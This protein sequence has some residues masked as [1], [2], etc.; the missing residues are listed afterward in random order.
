[1]ADAPT[2]IFLLA[3]GTPDTLDDV[4]PYFTH[5]RGGRTP[6][7]EAI[8]HLKE[9]YAMLGGRT[10]LT[11]ITNETARALEA[12]LNGEGGDY[13]A[14]VGMKHWHP[15]IVDVMPRI[16]ADGVRKLIAIVLAPH[17][18]SFSVAGYRKYVEQG[19]EKLG[20]PFDITFVQQ[21]HLHPK[22]VEMIAG[23]VREQLDAFAPGEEPT[24]LFSAHSLPARIRD[25]GDPYEQQLLASCEAVARAMGLATWR[26]A[27]QSA[28]GT[29]EPWLGPDI[30]EYLETMRAEGITRVVSCPIG[31]VSDHLEVQFDIDHEAQ[32]KARELGMELRRTRMPNATPELI[33]VLAAI[34]RDVERGTMTDAVRLPDAAAAR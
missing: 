26:F 9:R 7:P 10:P 19:Q 24:V 11:D 16:A 20:H 14:Y 32:Q 28:G 2:G 13:R 34:V 23:R 15:Y 12:R 25:A 31:F 33:A 3:Y 1:M 30:L 18:S 6:S 27:W 21:W 17:Y 29:S 22:F 5:I 8:E 4:G